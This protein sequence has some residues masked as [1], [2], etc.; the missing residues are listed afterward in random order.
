MNFILG[1]IL[2]L[3]LSNSASAR[4]WALVWSDEFDYTG[5]PDPDRWSF[6]V[7]GNMWA[8]GNNELQ[9]YTDETGANAWVED[10]RLIIEAR[11][12]QHTHPNGPTRE[13]TS[14]RLRTAQKGD[15]LY[16]RVEVR[17]KLPGGTGTWPAIWMLPTDWEYGNW[18]ASGEID[19][20]EYVG[21]DPGVIHWTVH[22]ESFNHMIGTQVGE[23]AFFINPEEQFYTYAVEWYEDRIDFLVDDTIYF[24]FE[25]RDDYTY[26]EWPFDK[27][28]H[29]LLNVAVGGDWG[30]AEGVDNSIFPVRMEIEYVRV[31]QLEGTG[32]HSVSV[33]SS[34]G[35]T[36]S[37]LPEASEYPHGTEVI[38]TAKPQN[39]KVF[40]FWTGT[41]NSKS[42]PLTQIIRQDIDIAAFFKDSSEVATNSEFLGGA[43][44]WRSSANGGGSGSVSFSDNRAVVKINSGGED[45]WSVNFYQDDIALISEE[46][47]ALSFTAS[48]DRNRT[49]SAGVGMSSAPWQPYV[50]EQTSLSALPG[51]FTIP[52]TYSGDTGSDNRIFFDCGGGESGTITFENVSLRHLNEVDD[53]SIAPLSRGATPL[54]SVS[55][56]NITNSGF[57]FLV[58]LSG[59]YTI[60]LFSLNGRE[61]FRETR[62]VSAGEKS[63]VALPSLL[64]PGVFTVKIDC[65]DCSHTFSERVVIY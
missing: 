23:Y 22:T 44:G 40:D 50:T 15:W 54:S 10:G 24:T 63:N 20:M 56:N 11:R 58:N 49:I 5:L 9:N 41:T 37:V 53:V 43:Y 59:Q 31:Y 17:A 35:G 7:D 21:Y 38:F 18:P 51:D 4:N 25:N 12:E 13:Y 30:G 26:R 16:G 57:N 62:S 36:V 64:P 1:F 46:K 28:F 42:N 65:R 8:W 47:Y 29:L 33:S 19:I 34:E 52:F 32:D 45:P 48:S 14:A 2:C 55:L 3:F 39:G 60:S 6:D 27:R 61:V